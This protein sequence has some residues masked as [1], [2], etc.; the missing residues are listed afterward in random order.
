MVCLGG[1]F[2]AGAKCGD[3]LGTV[4]EHGVLGE[5]AA[6]LLVWFLYYTTAS[7]SIMV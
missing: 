1:T 5:S 7:V 2:K 6:P 3:C 4:V